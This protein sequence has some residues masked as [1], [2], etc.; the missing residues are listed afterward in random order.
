MTGPVGIVEAVHDRAAVGRTILRWSSSAVFSA[1]LLIMRPGLI[2]PAMPIWESPAGHSLTVPASANGECL[3]DLMIGEARLR[4]AL[5]DTGASG[6][7]VL[8]RNQA[9]QAGIDLEGL[10]FTNTYDSANGSARFAI[11]RVAWA[12]IGDAFDLADLPVAVTEVDQSQAL[13]GIQILRHLN[14]RL[15]GDHCEFGASA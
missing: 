11:T 4:G 8:G 13:I 3:V 15:R 12:R 9:R 7:V 5:A 6:F 2:G 1:G 10:R 14:F